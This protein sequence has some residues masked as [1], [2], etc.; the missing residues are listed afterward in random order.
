MTVI[1]NT[2]TNEFKQLLLGKQKINFEKEYRLLQFCVLEEIN[3]ETILFNKMLD[4]MM[5]LSEQEKAALQKL[6]CK[7]DKSLIPFAEDW[8]I[9]PINHDDMR[10]SDQFVVLGENL[11]NKNHITSFTILP[12]TDC[13]ARCFYCYELGIERNNMTEQT[14]KDVA[15]YIAEKTKDN[16]ATLH[17]FGGEPLFNYKAIDTICS[18]LDILGIK[19]KSSMISNAFLFNDEIISKAKNNWNLTRV[20]ITLDGTEKV[21]N[22]TKAYRNIGNANPFI[23]VTDNIEKLAKNDIAVSIRLNLSESNYEDLCA[24]IDWL[25]KRYSGTNNISAYCS[26]LYDMYKLPQNILD[27]YMEQQIAIQN[28]LYKKK[29]LNVGFRGKLL[30]GCM[31]QNDNAVVISPKGTLGKCEHFVEGEKTYGSI[32]SDE[33]DVNVLNYWKHSTIT[34]QCKECSDYSICGGLDSC[35]NFNGDCKKTEKLKVYKTRMQ[36]LNEYEKWKKSNT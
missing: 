32:Y 7:I 19:Y 24:L 14:A 35:P 11:I 2:N 23:T 29:L 15:K 22:K 31:A 26:M 10:L 33:F 36:M 13:N 6:P 27:N 21:Y 25:G 28:L 5:I 17:W 18:E 12:T 20:Q 9:V 3:G 34:E 16:K 4:K 8:H 1:Y 30:R